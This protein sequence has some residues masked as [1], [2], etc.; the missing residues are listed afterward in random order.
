LEILFSV[1]TLEAALDLESFSDNGLDD[2]TLEAPPK[3]S[4]ED[5]WAPPALEKA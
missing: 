2:G 1:K 4:A 5:T 3:I